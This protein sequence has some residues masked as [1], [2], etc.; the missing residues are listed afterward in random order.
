MTRQSQD[1]INC[2]SEVFLIVLQRLRRSSGSIIFRD[3][4]V[5]LHIF[6]SH[7]ILLPRLLWR[8]LC[9]FCSHRNKNCL[10]VYVSVFV[11]ADLCFRV[12]TLILTLAEEGRDRYP[13][14]SVYLC[15]CLC[16]CVSVYVCMCLCLWLLICVFVC[17]HSP[18]HWQKRAGTRILR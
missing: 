1:Q 9:G 16:L 2:N 7:N 12:F 10:C 6:S 18:S 15:S 3:R 4:L 11:V 17:S 13:E 8:I 5:V 14:V